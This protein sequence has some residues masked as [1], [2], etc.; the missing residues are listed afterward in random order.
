MVDMHSQYGMYQLLLRESR[1]DTCSG[2]KRKTGRVYRR[3]MKIKHRKELM[4]IIRNCGYNPSVG[5]TDWDWADGVWQPVG[6]H[7]KY[8]KNSNPQ[9]YWKRHSNKILRQRKEIYRGNQYR[10]C[11]DYRWTLY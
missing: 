10:K 3:E 5:Y 7:I 8:P 4:Q 11:F 9:K 2:S 6:T 1:E